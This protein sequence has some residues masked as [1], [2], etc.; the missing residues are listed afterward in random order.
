MNER[1]LLGAVWPGEMFGPM[2]DAFL[3]ISSLCDAFVPTVAGHVDQKYFGRINNCRI[4][5]S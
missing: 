2:G 5:V 4:T 1:T 3:K